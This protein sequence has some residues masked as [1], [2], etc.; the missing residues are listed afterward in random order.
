MDV[1]VD[2]RFFSSLR[3]G[4]RSKWTEGGRDGVDNED[5]IIQKFQGL[6]TECGERGN[7]SRSRWNIEWWVIEFKCKMGK[8]GGRGDSGE[9]MEG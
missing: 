8:E 4:D 2:T 9:T 1:D 7:W 3:M 6:K 5:K